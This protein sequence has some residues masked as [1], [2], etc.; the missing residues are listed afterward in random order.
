MES[1]VEVVVVLLQAADTMRQRAGVVDKVQL[2]LRAVAMLW[3]ILVV[4]AA[5]PQRAVQARRMVAMAGLAISTCSGL[6]NTEVYRLRFLK[7][8]SVVLL[9]SQLT[10]IK[11]SL[12]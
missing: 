5:G 11:S 4:V 12:G 10:E 9:G 1:V 8:L 3:Q 2:A 6:S 7:C